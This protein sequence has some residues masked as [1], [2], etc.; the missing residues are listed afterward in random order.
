MTAEDDRARYWNSAYAKGDTAKS[1]YQPHAPTSVALISAASRP[2][3]S[4]IDVGGGASTLV[5]DLSAASWGDLTVLDVSDAGMQVA[6]DRIGAKS[7]TV[8]WITADLLSW[9][10]ERT[11]DVWHDRAFLHFLGTLEQQ[12]QYHRAL[13]RA[14]HPGSRIVIGVFGPGGPE[15]C[16]GLSVTRYDLPQLSKFLGSTFAVTA[17]AFEAHQTPSGAVQQFQWI[18]AERC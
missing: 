11:F 8:T 17:D 9:S 14:T 6:R 12:E 16:S 15:E 3:S 18:V 7:N 1:W 13:V 4:V 2:E 10:P 5:D